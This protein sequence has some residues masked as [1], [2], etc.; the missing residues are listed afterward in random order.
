MF[1]CELDNCLPVESD[2]EWA[3]VEESGDVRARPERTSRRGLPVDDTGLFR[4][5]CQYS[6][7]QNASF[8]T[9][10]F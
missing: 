10:D 7:G 9:H 8:V 1:G 5:L 2:G 4:D 6:R 3:V